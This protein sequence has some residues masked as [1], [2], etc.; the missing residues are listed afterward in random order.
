[1]R[2]RAPV[3]STVAFE[4]WYVGPHLMGASAPPADHEILA[5]VWRNSL[6]IRSLA[7]TSSTVALTIHVENF[8]V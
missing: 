1:M 6:W 8:G 4:R 3:L 5:K 2:Q 7:L